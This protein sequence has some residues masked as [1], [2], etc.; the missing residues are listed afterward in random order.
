MGL[1]GDGSLYVGVNLEFPGVP[2]NQSVHAEQFLVANLISGG[3]QAL[4]ALA[5]NAAPCGHCR[6]FYSEL[7]CADALHFLFPA[8][9]AA[10]PPA[11]TTPAPAEPAGAASSAGRPQDGKQEEEQRRQ[12]QADGAPGPVRWRLA[13]LLPA[14]F[15]PLDL[16]EADSEPLLLQ[17]Q[18]RS[19]SWEPSA[20][21]ALAGN[22]GGGSSCHAAAAQAALAAARQSYAPY[23]RCYSGAAVVTASGQVYSGSY[24][25]S[26]AYNPGLHPLQ[27]ALVAAV[28][29]GLPSYQQVGGGRVSKLAPGRPRTA[30]RGQLPGAPAAGPPA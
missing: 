21:Q 13:Q 22:G 6:Q 1:A 18:D 17:P 15:G 19:L 12:R 28:K 30:P 8:P 25:E 10:P 23:S 20:V 5:V 11:T 3:Q 29:D 24:L 26:A 9:S 2:L 27:A 4:Q 16:L 7:V 14:R